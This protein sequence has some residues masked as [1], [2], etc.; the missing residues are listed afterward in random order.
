MDG[1]ITLTNDYF[2]FAI[3]TNCP[4]FIEFASTYYSDVGRVESI[5]TICLISHIL[6]SPALE[7]DIMVV[8]ITWTRSD[9]DRL[10]LR[11]MMMIR[12]RGEEEAVCDRAERRG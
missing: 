9:D 5:Y 3:I 11:V 2:V 4:I 8:V 7:E 1:W 12:R 6:C 10:R